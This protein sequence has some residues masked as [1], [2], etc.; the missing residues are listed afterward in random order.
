MIPESV[1]GGRI[2][3]DNRDDIAILMI[4]YM[5]DVEAAKDEWGMFCRKNNEENLIHNNDKRFFTTIREKRR[6][7]HAGNGI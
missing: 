4:T 5:C 7:N 2:R 3:S 6:E 1:A